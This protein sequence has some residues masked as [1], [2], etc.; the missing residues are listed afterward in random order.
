[1]IRNKI[2]VVLSRFSIVSA[3]VALSLTL[4]Y[5]LPED[6]P[7]RV[8]SIP[9][10]QISFSPLQLI[11]LFIAIIS[12]TGAYWVLISNPEIERKGWLVQQVLP[13]LVLPAINIF[14]FALILTQTNKSYEWWGILF[15]GVLTFSIILYAEYQVL[16]SNVSTNTI[17]TVLL[18]S[19]AHALFMAFTIALRASIS[20]IFL[21][22]PAIVL[23][24]IFVSYRTI[25]LRTDGK[26]KS[27]WI[28]VVTFICFQFAIALYYLFL[29]PNQYGLILTAILFVSNA[30]IARIGQGDRKRLY[31]E[32]LVIGVFVLAVLL[33]GNLL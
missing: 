32:P 13:N 7:A 5:F 25:Y 15:T 2:S 9:G 23:A 8:L 10:L 29:T 22:I 1:M 6:V 33:L 17:F 21:I 11:P 18:I 12:L 31:I 4:I 28:Y 3:L 14:I 16:K 19:L 30:V 26:F 20:R 27:Y 24:S